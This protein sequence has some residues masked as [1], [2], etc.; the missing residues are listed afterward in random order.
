MPQTGG[1]VGIEKAEKITAYVTD[2]VGRPWCPGESWPPPNNN[3]TKTEPDASCAVMVDKAN[4]F[5]ASLNNNQQ[6]DATFGWGSNQRM[7]FEFLP[8]PGGPAGTARQ[9]IAFRNLNNSQK[10]KMEDFIKA[11]TSATGWDKI[12]GIRN[13]EKELGDPPYRDPDGYWLSFFGTPSVDSGVE[14]GFRFEGH[15]LSFH[16][17]ILDCKTYAPTPAFWGASEYNNN[18][19]PL[20]QE[21]DLAQDLYQSLSNGQKQQAG[22]NSGGNS[23]ISAKKRLIDPYPQNAGIS[24][25]DLNQQQKATVRNIILAYVGN[26]NDDIANKRMQRLETEGFDNLRFV[27]N[28]GSYRV[29]GSTFVIVYDKQN[30]SHVH[31]VWRDY[32]GDWGEDLLERHMRMMH[33]GQ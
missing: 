21:G 2:T 31:S 11:A 12:N 16:T 27:Y 22:N 3:V 17:S 24:V 28:N 23:A 4:D 7:Y 19:N 5:L 29:Q 6:N 8:P 15:H 18:N 33:S 32:D 20:K 26:M 25:G 1:G 10:T 14:W 13:L 9:G 30:N